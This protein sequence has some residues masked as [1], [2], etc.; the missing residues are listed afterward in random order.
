MVFDKNILPLNWQ[1][2]FSGANRDEAPDGSDSVTGYRLLRSVGRP[3]HPP[4]TAYT[5]QILILGTWH[6]S[7][8]YHKPQ[9]NKLCYLHIQE[10]PEALIHINSFPFKTQSYH[11]PRLGHSGPLELQGS[12]PFLSS[13]CLTAHSLAHIATGF[14]HKPKAGLPGSQGVTILQRAQ[15][16]WMLATTGQSTYTHI[17]TQP[18]H[19]H[20]TPAQCRH[21]QDLVTASVSVPPYLPW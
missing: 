1:A 17:L 6:S 19:A 14:P 12:H 20:P 8:G 5:T 9:E 21:Q 2:P 16:N 7:V 13:S 3:S 10:G 18:M 11:H 4:I 15:A